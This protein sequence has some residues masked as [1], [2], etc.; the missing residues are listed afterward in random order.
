MIDILF[1]HANASSKIYQ[2]LATNNAAIEP[3]IWAAMLANSVRSIGYEAQILDAEAERID[4]LTTA[5][6]ISEY[7]AR[8]ICFVVYGQQPSASSQN[9][10]GA[11]KTALE[12]KNLHPDSFVVFVGAHVSALPQETMESHDFIDALCQNEGVYT[13]RDL[14]AVKNLKDEFILSRVKGLVF[15]NFQG[16]VVLN[17][18]SDIVP[19]NKLEIDLPGMAWDLLP[20]LKKYRTAGWHSW[21]NNSEKEPFAALYTSLGCPYRCSFCMINIINRTKQGEGVSAADSNKFRHWSPD[22]IIKQFD[23]FAEQGVRNIKIADELFVLKPRHFM[24]ICQMIKERGYDFNIW[25]YSRVDTCKTE[26][27]DALSSAGVKWLGLGIENPD[28][29]LRKEAHKDGFIDVKITDLINRIQGAGISVGA[30]YIFGLPHDTLATMQNTLDFAIENSTDMVNFYSAMA[31][32]GSPLYLD[33]KKNGIELPSSYSGYSQHSYDSLNTS[34]E[35]LTAAQIL[36]FRDEAW[37]TYHTNPAYL[38]QLENK[39]GL[40]SRKEL[41]KTTSIVLKRKIL[42]D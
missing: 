12:F 42:G 4:Y 23:Y 11:S 22:F 40:A 29:V 17:D 41:E 2:G 24:A 39:F 15:R 33:A 31:Y 20:P 28:E 6:R 37:N 38:N 35:N 32:P 5:K 3:P 34:N 36:K 21:S 10:E 25:A 7:D 26:Y 13:L 9:M 30:N 19:S 8:I 14:L 16:Q 1:V 27:L 18:P